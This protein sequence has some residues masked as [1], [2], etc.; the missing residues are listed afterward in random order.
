MHRDLVVARVRCF[1]KNDSKA[2]VGGKKNDTGNYGRLQAV[3]SPF[4][5]MQQAQ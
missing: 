5:P 3:K 2:Q 1:L 4:L